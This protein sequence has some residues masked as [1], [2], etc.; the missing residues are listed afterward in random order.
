M[1]IEF[2]VNEGWVRRPTNGQTK[3]RTSAKDEGRVAI[4]KPRPWRVKGKVQE[5]SGFE[6]K[7]LFWTE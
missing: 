6:Y 3:R 5:K 7:K 4:E 2:I 1:T